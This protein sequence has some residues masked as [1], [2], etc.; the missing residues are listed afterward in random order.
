MRSL[1]L[2]LAPV[3]AIRAPSPVSVKVAVEGK[4]S[5]LA[6]MKITTTFDPRP[7]AVVLVSSRPNQRRPSS[8]P[9]I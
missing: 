4:L 5:G 7:Q 8:S 3:M 1:A 2:A 9:C 6:S